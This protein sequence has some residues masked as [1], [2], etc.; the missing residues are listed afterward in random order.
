MAHSITQPMWIMNK[1]ESR[2]SMIIWP[3]VLQDLKN[4]IQLL[5]IPNAAQWV[6]EVSHCR[7]KEKNNILIHKIHRR[8]GDRNSYNR[9]NYPKID[10]CNVERL[11]IA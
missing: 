9:F 11:E 1:D 3:E 7:L 5:D 4:T 8:C 10:S 2:E 6:E